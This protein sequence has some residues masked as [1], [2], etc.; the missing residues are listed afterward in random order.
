MVAV[1]S[2]CLSAQDGAVTGHELSYLLLLLWAGWKSLDIHILCCF[3]CAGAKSQ[4]ES[5]F[6]MMVCLCCLSGMQCA[7]GMLCARFII[8]CLQ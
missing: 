8:S 6:A 2:V 1:K 7:A 4:H 5:P 3:L